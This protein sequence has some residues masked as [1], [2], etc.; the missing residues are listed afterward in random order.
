MGNSLGCQKQILRFAQDDR[1]VQI[2]PCAGDDMSAVAFVDGG[3]DFVEG[4]PSLVQAKGETALAL[5]DVAGARHS[6][7]LV[8]AEER[9]V[10]LDLGAAAL[11]ANAVDDLGDLAYLVEGDAGARE[12]GEIFRA[13]DVRGVD[14][15]PGCRVR[16]RASPDASEHRH[17]RRGDEEFASAE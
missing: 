8:A 7:L 4:F 12:V 11:A 10:S 9:V 15:G 13:E 6:I 16:T 17:Y 14:A 5:A 3:A 1:E 2:P